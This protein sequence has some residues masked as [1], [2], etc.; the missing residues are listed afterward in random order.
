MLNRPSKRSEA[1]SAG[2]DDTFRANQQ[3]DEVQCE[4]LID[5]FEQRG[6]NINIEQFEDV[7]CDSVKS[8]ETN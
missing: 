5:E 3:I 1:G 6:K 2:S 8:V 4:A 7:S